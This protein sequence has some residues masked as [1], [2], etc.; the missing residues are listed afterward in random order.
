MAEMGIKV[1][2]ERF[3]DFYNNGNYLIFRKKISVRSTND[4]IR[5]HFIY[6]FENLSDHYADFFYHHSFN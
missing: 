3:I 1:V 4:Q 6:K 5:F 2:N